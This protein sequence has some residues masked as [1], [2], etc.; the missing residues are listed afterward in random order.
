MIDP[1]M[2][3]D[4]R[5]RS[6]QNWWNKNH[7][8][9]KGHDWLCAH[10][11]RIAYAYFFPPELFDDIQYITKRYYNSEYKRLSHINAW[12][13]WKFV[14]PLH[15]NRIK[16]IEGAA[17]RYEEKRIKLKELKDSLPEKTEKPAETVKKTVVVIERKVKRVLNRPT[18]T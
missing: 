8:R 4:H 6:F 9:R 14:H 16:A 7:H 18:S 17:R 11:R 1:Q 15:N 3:S 10:A 2:S 13:L 5:W 12:M